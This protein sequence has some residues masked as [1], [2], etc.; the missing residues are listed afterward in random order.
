MLARLRV[1]RHHRVV[2]VADLHD[3]GEHP[4][5]IGEHGGVATGPAEVHVVFQRH[6]H[7]PGLVGLV[8]LLVAHDH[9]A[10]DRVQLA[11]L[12][13]PALELGISLHRRLQVGVAHVVEHRRRAQFAQVHLGEPQ[14]LAHRDGQIGHVQAVVEVGIVGPLDGVELQGRVKVLDAEVDHLLDRAPD[15]ERVREPLGDH[16][17]RVVPQR[18]DAVGEVGGGL[19]THVFVVLVVLVLSLVTHG[20]DEGRLRLNRHL[21]LGQGLAQGSELVALL[22]RARHQREDHRPGLGIGERLAE[23]QPAGL[24]PR[25][26]LDDVLE[27]AVV[28]GLDADPHVVD[29][30]LPLG[31]DELGR[32]QALDQLADRLDHPLDGV[33]RGLVLRRVDHEGAGGHEQLVD[34]IE[35]PLPGE[36][37]L[38]LLLAGRCP[39]LREVDAFF[40]GLA[41]APS[42]SARAAAS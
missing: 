32:T 5:P 26:D 17:V 37:D 27:V 16:H 8:A 41:H 12:L 11:V 28:P 39:H 21:A 23:G 4:Q 34:Q 15:L 29:V 7:A 6:P 33:V 35:P 22:G 1:R 31:H 18:R 24:V 36:A 19:L 14:L 30:R 9:H 13:P 3:A 20:L 42:S 40:G 10:G 25:Q 38:L 2:V